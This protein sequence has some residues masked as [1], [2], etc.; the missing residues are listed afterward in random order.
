N[1]VTEVLPKLILP[2][3]SK[4][5]NSSG[6]S[7]QNVRSSST[8]TTSTTPI[9]DI[10]DKLEK[11]II[12]GKV[13]LVDDEG[14]PLKNVDYAGDHDSEDKVEPV[15]NEMASFLASKMVGFGINSLHNGE[16][17][18]RMLRYSKKMMGYSFYYLPENNVIVAR[19]VK[20]FETSLITQKA[21][22]SLED[23]KV[24]QEE[25][26]H[27]FENTSMHHDEEEQE[28]V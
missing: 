26:T 15:D 9:I 24:I 5:A 14:K 21:S 27:S 20:F 2:V 25:D 23:L 4:E 3:H 6:F 1:P 22:G 19:N 17:L 7:T 8:S 11:V 28:I 13:S 16:I 10:I 12:D 18:M